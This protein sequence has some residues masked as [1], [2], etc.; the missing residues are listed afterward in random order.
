METPQN[1]LETWAVVELMGHQKEVGFVTTQYYGTACMF[2]IDVPDLPEREKTL[3]R[4]QWVGDTLVPAGTVIRLPPE[5]GRSRMVGVSAVYALNP[6]DQE[7]AMK[8]IEDAVGAH[9]IK[10]VSL[11]GCKQLSL[12]AE[13]PDSDE[14][15]DEEDEDNE[16]ERALD[17]AGI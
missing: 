7:T 12:Q 16:E 8:V 1:H 10:I 4:P 14:E 11:A 13:E 9:D 3:H 5:P 2:K 15:E 17:R 6:C